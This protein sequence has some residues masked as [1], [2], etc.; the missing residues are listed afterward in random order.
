MYFPAGNA[1]SGLITS[2]GSGHDI[3][4]TPGLAHLNIFGEMTRVLGMYTYVQISGISVFMSSVFFPHPPVAS[5][6]GL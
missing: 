1:V 4:A 3:Q 5:V 6:D 2:G